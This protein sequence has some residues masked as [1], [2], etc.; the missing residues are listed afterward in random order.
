MVYKNNHTCYKWCINTG[1][2]A[3]NV[4]LAL[5]S[6]FPALGGCG[7]GRDPPRRG[8]AILVGVQRAARVLGDLVEL[9][10]G[11]GPPLN[12]HHQTV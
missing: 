12:R 9:L 3:R 7:S 4:T 10:L 5:N 2:L 8:R 11:L 1:T 6:P